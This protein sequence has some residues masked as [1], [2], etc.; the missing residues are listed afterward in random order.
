MKRRTVTLTEADLRGRGSPC[1][2]VNVQS[3]DEYFPRVLFWTFKATERAVLRQ[4]GGVVEVVMEHQDKDAMGNTR[5]STTPLEDAA[6]NLNLT[7]DPWLGAWLGALPRSKGDTR[8]V[9]NAFLQ[10]KESAI[11]VPCSSG[12]FYS[13]HATHCYVKERFA[14][15]LIMREFDN[16][17]VRSQM[18]IDL[19]ARAIGG[20][21]SVQ[22]TWHP[23]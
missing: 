13:R 15:L 19:A 4:E 18:R 16:P 17:R 20:D 2:Q 8:E 5:W 14:D 3:W 11:R 23:G 10:D 9:G 22:V 1:A 21:P 7:L 6:D 12:N